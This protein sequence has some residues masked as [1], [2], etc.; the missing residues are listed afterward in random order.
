MSDVL[1]GAAYTISRQPD[2]VLVERSPG[3]VVTINEQPAMFADIRQAC[4][5]AA[6]RKVLLRGSKVNV[7]LSVE[8]LFELGE[9]IAKMGLRI[10]VV[11]THDASDESVEFLETVTFNRGGS[12]EFFE[13]EKTA[14]EWL[15]AM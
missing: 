14:I 2:F 13:H 6:C 9:V 4:E 5:L 12:F 7:R 1:P 11:E 10:A 15:N 3:A 8:D